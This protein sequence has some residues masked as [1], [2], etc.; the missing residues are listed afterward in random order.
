M[1]V[2][3]WEL[4]AA[5]FVREL[6]SGPISPW[7]RRSSKHSPPQMLANVRAATALAQ[8]GI[9]IGAV[10]GGVVV[11]RLDWCRI[12]LSGAVPG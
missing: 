7:P 6:P 9:P 4:V 2:D 11:E 12:I 10:P 1:M 3:D 8:A 5:G